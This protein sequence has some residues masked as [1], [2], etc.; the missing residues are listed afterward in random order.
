MSLLFELKSITKA[1]KESAVRSIVTESVPDGTFYLSLILSALV[2]T[3]GLLLSDPTVII[4]GVLIAPIL[5]PVLGFS[6]SFSVSDMLL[7][8]RSVKTIFKSFIYI[9]VTSIA[10]V[11]LFGSL[12]NVQSSEVIIRS[13]PS[14]LYLFITIVATVAIVLF[15]VRGRKEVIG[16]ANAAVA[17]SLIPNIATIGIGLARFDF[18]FAQG[19][20]LFLIIN[21]LGIVFA[22]I[23]M[24]SLFNLGENRGLV[25]TSLVHGETQK[26]KTKKRVKREKETEMSVTKA[27]K[28]KEVV[29][30]K[31]LSVKEETTATE[32]PETENEQQEEK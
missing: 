9:L 1:Q 2:S 16:L 25:K 4:A 30:E 13:S 17:L 8:T 14:L 20:F 29:E 28:E 31:P 10:V 27:P 32:E 12:G 6:L 18:Q 22:S 15:V 11:L 5:F 19:S 23:I 7:M 3:F 21:I 26:E 24:F